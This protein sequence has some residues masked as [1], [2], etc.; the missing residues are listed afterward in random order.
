MIKSFKYRVRRGQRSTPG[1]LVDE[2]SGEKILG[3][4]LADCLIFC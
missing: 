1:Y 4:V 2:I 3:V